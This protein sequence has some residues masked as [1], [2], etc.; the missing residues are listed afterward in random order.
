[1]LTAS[2]LLSLMFNYI[3]ITG[4]RTQC[5]NRTQY[6]SEAVRSAQLYIRMQIVAA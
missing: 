2:R 5:H 4:P 6:S 1:M 3:N